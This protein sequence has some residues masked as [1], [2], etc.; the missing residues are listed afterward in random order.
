[1]SY[2]LFVVESWEVTDKYVN[3]FIASVHE[4]V[5]RQYAPNQSEQYSRSK[6]HFE[7]PK[8]QSRRHTYQVP[9]YFNSPAYQLTTIRP[10][11]L[12]LPNTLHSTLYE[13]S[14]YNQLIHYPY[15]YVHL[16]SHFYERYH[17]YE[18]LY[19]YPKYN[20]LRDHD[21]YSTRFKNIKHGV[22]NPIV[23]NSSSV[24]K[25]KNQELRFQDAIFYPLES[26]PSKP[27][28]S[29]STEIPKI[30]RKASYPLPGY[31]STTYN[32]FYQ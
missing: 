5:R 11:A 32:Q 21:K 31:Y 9:Q 13:T 15:S 30:R 19:R 18:Q 4:N 10:S 6:Y 7:P 26:Y 25:K 28:K 16:K 17:L 3:D 20:F 27:Y 12:N 29:K 22:I 8:P 14:L 24:D 23:S 1:M 2:H